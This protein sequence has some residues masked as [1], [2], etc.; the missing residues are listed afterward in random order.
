M[1][2][3]QPPSKMHTIAL[4]I[5][6]LAPAIKCDSTIESLFLVDYSLFS[7]TQYTNLLQHLTNTTV[8]SIAASN[9]MMTGAEALQYFAGLHAFQVVHATRVV[10]TVPVSSDAMRAMVGPYLAVMSSNIAPV[11]IVSSV[12]SPAPNWYDAFPAIM[13]PIALFVLILTVVACSVC[14]AVYCFCPCNK[15][16]TAVVVQEKPEAVSTQGEKKQQEATNSD[17]AGTVKGKIQPNP[18]NG[19]RLSAKMDRT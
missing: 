11:A 14:W 16:E 13:G 2:H 6:T 3:N 18:F 8:T 7:P 5:L 12:S 19:I 9:E 1:I 15:V 17:K 10:V 4:I